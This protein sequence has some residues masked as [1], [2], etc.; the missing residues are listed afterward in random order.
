MP[1]ECLHPS[2]IRRNFKTGKVIVRETGRVKRLILEDPPAAEDRH[3]EL[4][5]T[6]AGVPLF[7]R[8]R[9][10]LLFLGG[11]WDGSTRVVE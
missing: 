6:G 4:P 3:A 2:Y 11:S 7:T 8:F 5:E 9:R 10:G 1:D